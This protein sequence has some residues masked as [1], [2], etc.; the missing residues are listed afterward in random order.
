M[1]RVIHDPELIGTALNADDVGSVIAMTLRKRPSERSGNV[2]RMPKAA[3]IKVGS[4]RLRAGLVT[5]LLG[6]SAAG[7]AAGGSVSD[8]LHSIDLNEYSLGGF[9]FYSSSYY[10]GVEDF[11]GIFPLPTAYEHPILNDFAFY[12]RDAEFSLRKIFDNDW[13]LAGTTKLQ[14]LGYGSSDSP[15][16]EGMAR[17]NWTIQAGA[18]VGRQ[19]GPIRID[20]GGQTDL[21]GEHG[22]Q[23]YTLK[24]ASP[25]VSDNWYLIPQFEVRYQS[26]ELINHYFGVTEAEARPGRPAY[27]PGGAVTYSPSLTMNWRFH[28]RWYATATLAY[29]VLPNEILDSPITIPD[30]GFRAVLGVAY[31]APAFVALD[32]DRVDSWPKIEVS[33]GAFFA[34][35]TTNV[36][37]G[38][39]PGAKPP[40]LEDLVDLDEAQTTGVVNAYWRLNDFHRFEFAYF[41]LSRSGTLELTEPTLVDQVTFPIAAILN[42]SFDTK[43]FKIGYAFSLFHDNQKELSVFGGLHFTD[44]SYRTSDGNQEVSSSTDTIM[45]VIGVRFNAGP[46]NRI[47]AGARIDYYNMDF[48]Q[49]SGTLLDFEFYGE[50]RFNDML[51]IG[52]AYRIYSQKVDSADPDFLAQYSFKY[53]GPSVMLIGRFL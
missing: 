1:R 47:S 10:E 8:F 45:P 19:F 6:L 11:N 21:L 31:D 39:L 5:A 3:H 48:N 50:Y 9:Y 30:N 12:V 14:T 27:Q 41:N 18:S 44:I 53:T 24:F 34:Q 4:G 36:N 40:D 2:S 13:E 49:I 32:R 22:G 20:A 33:L 37:I 51:S 26:D 15:A 52:A 46:T 29:D 43:V 28:E 42:S 25:V 17:R 38:E 23:E 7:P 16:L 35:A